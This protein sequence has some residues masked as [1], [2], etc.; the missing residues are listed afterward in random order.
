MWEFLG[1]N[2]GQVTHLISFYTLFNVLVTFFGSLPISS[3]LLN[4]KLLSVCKHCD[5]E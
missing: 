2:N 1:E 5:E 3:H 4:N